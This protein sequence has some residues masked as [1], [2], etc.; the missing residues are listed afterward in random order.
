MRPVEAKMRPILRVRRSKKVRPA[1]A[2]DYS[3][4][5][6]CLTLHSEIGCRFKTRPAMSFS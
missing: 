6:R 2:R 5:S 4:D 3:S 1:G